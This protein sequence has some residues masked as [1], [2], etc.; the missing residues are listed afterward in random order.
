MNSTLRRYTVAL[1]LVAV[2]LSTPVFAAPV[3]DE[4]SRADQVIVRVISK[5]AQK[6]LGLLPLEGLIGPIP[7]PDHP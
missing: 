5:L 7:S 4:G 6:F 3:R 2:L 1:T